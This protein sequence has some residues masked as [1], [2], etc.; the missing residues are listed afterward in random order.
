MATSEWQAKL[1]TQIANLPRRV[2][3]ARQIYQ[4][5]GGWLWKYH[6]GVPVGFLAAV[7]Q[8]ES[9]GKMSSRG[10][11]SLGEVGYFQITSSF[12]PKVGLPAGSRFDAETNIFLGCLEY[13]MSAVEMAMAVPQLQ[14]GT[15]DSWKVARLAFAIGAG[16]TKKLIQAANPVPGDVFGAIKRYVDRTGGVALGSQSA[17]KVWF[18]VHAIDLQWATGI[19]IFPLIG[20]GAPVTIPSPPTGDYT[21][22]AEIAR[23]MP[24]KFRGDLLAVGLGA[25]AFLA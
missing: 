21:L 1:Q 6:G 18:R 11:P 22:P 8:F 17:G 15:A 3:H 2:E 25:L 23:Y 5:L 7:I 9:G 12:P 13:Q 20:W 16:G 19:Q 10:D 24:S 4:E 14:L